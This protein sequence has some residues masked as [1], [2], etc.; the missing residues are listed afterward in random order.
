MELKKI[1]EELP[2]HVSR[3][4]NKLI[5]TSNYFKKLHLISDIL[6]GSF[7]LY[8]HT[9]IQISLFENTISDSIE[10]TLETL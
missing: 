4:L 7:R 3:P 2:V 8:G 9:L 6:L 5:E 10:L 1:V